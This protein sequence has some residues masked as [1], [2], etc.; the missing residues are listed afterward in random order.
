MVCPSCN[1]NM[2]QYEKRG[3]GFSS[4]D[5]YMT[6]TIQICP[7][8][9]AMAIEYYCAKFIDNPDVKPHFELL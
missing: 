8:C 6:Y 7:S 5:E 4:T 9:S 3:D 2:H 1:Q